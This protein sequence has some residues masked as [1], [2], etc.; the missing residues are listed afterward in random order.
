M[1][2]SAFSFLGTSL[3]NALYFKRFWFVWLFW[4]AFMLIDFSQRLMV[5]GDPSTGGQIIDSKLL[6]EEIPR[7]DGSSLSVYLEKLEA[8][9]APPKESIEVIDLALAQSDLSLD[10][11]VW[12]S[13]G[14]EFKLLAILGAEKKIAVLRQFEPGTDDT[15]IVDVGVGD[16]LGDFVVT[17]IL[18]HKLLLSG[19]LKE[20]AQLQ[21]F[22]SVD[23]AHSAG[24]DLP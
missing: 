9:S 1:I 3:D 2:R 7:L 5:R 16:P 13:A 22:K 18:P 11:E 15:S 19:S 12:R 21:L 24:G 14:L 17:Q 20:S 23:L 6:F 8:L 10:T 4:M